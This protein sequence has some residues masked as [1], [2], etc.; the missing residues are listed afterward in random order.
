[1]LGDPAAALPVLYRDK[2]CIDAASQTAWLA[3]ECKGVDYLTVLVSEEADDAI[4]RI[5]WPEGDRAGEGDGDEEGGAAAAAAAAADMEECDVDVPEG[6]PPVVRRGGEEEEGG[7]T[8]PLRLLEQIQARY[9]DRE[10]QFYPSLS[11][12]VDA[13]RSHIMRLPGILPSVGTLPREVR[14]AAA[15]ALSWRRRVQSPLPP[16]RGGRRVVR[17]DGAAA[18]LRVPR[19]G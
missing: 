10:P 6:I 17:G 14:S 7:T 12:C 13:A 1:M 5:V 19:A 3:L 4:P 15:P 9:P 18:G 2:A 11:M 8:D 16:V